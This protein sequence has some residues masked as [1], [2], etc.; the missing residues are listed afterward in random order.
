MGHP[1]RVSKWSPPLCWS[2]LLRNTAILTPS[3]EPERANN[4]VRGSRPMYRFVVRIPPRHQLLSNVVSS[5]LRIHGHSA[6][7]PL[8]RYASTMVYKGACYC[9]AV[10]YE[11]DIS[12]PDEARTSLCHCK[13]CKVRSL[14]VPLLAR[15]FC[16]D[17][18]HMPSC[19]SIDLKC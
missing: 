12:S 6:P 19:F 1:F 16:W 13:N 2:F 9:K 3:H 11:I 5:K 17:S 7:L 4:T 18:V 15:N 10:K 14:M 8:S